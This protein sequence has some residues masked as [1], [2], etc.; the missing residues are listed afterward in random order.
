M[1]DEGISLR[2]E[3]FYNR[4]RL[5]S[6]ALVLAQAALIAAVPLVVY[7]TGGTKY[8]FSHL[9]YLPI[10]LGAFAFGPEASVATALVLTIALGPLMPLDVASNTPQSLLNW[11]QRGMAFTF[12]G[13][14]TGA[15]FLLVRRS[16]LQSCWAARHTPHSGLLNERAL[17]HEL[18]ALIAPKKGK[19]A[20]GRFSFLRLGVNNFHDIV[21][22]IGY[23]QARI[24]PLWVSSALKGAIPQKCVFFDLGRDSLGLL[25]YRISSEEKEWMPRFMNVLNT[26]FP[27]GESKVFVDFSVALHSDR[28]ES[29]PLRVIVNTGK[30]LLQ[31][32]KE[33]SPLVEFVH[34]DFESA[35]R[36][37]RILSAI[38]S[39][40]SQ[41]E[42]S[43]E[44]QP[45]V[46]IASGAVTGVEALLRWKSPR[47]GSVSPGDFIPLVEN[48]SLI[49]PL[50]EWV[51]DTAT[52]Q[53]G[54]WRRNGLNLRMAI[55][56]SARNFQNTDLVKHL[57]IRVKQQKIRPST[58][59]IELTESS[60]L[61]LFDKC[62]RHVIAL[63]KMGV[64]VAIDDFGAGYTSLSYLQKLPID[65]LKIDQVF[66]HN[67]LSNPGSAAIVKSSISLKEAFGFKI[68]CEG[69][70]DRETADALAALGAHEG[71]GYH[72]AKPMSAS[73]LERWLGELP[74]AV[75]RIQER[76]H[77]RAMEENVK[78][79]LMNRIKGETVNHPRFVTPTPLT[80][81]TGSR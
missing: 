72:F 56:F 70:E 55:N 25:V 30:T 77:K 45:K 76:S 29:D 34:E 53:A 33:G 65:T 51:I 49:H 32:Q 36:A 23:D 2:L 59:E 73:S 11:M 61:T 14:M 50:T 24:L 46:N 54:E 75:T 38:P 4:G 12:I 35:T 37:Q 10:V 66:V 28:G 48:T 1:Y 3:R 8:V 62:L 67:M 6:V 64:K 58:I 16:V 52:K 71:Q 26:P 41:G 17:I 27:V 7:Q 15:L 60:I 31:A 68:I 69:I 13:L 74:P 78:A 20:S 47:F 42:L 43:L 57:L 9:A 19:P 18:T 22:V 39:A 21:D 79:T 80:P 44:Y 63:R 40:L 5:A 81:Q